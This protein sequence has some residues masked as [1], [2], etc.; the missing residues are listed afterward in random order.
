ASGPRPSVPGGSSSAATPSCPGPVGS[1]PAPYGEGDDDGEGD[2]SGEGEGD[3]VG[4]GVGG[5]GGGGGGAVAKEIAIDTTVPCRARL[6][7]PGIWER[8]TPDESE[9]SVNVWTLKP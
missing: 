8:T 9:G 2:G 5:G 1:P 3:G 4:V 6:P 7:A